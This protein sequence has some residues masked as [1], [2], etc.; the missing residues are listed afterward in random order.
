VNTY[1]DF[2]DYTDPVKPYIDNRFSFELLPNLMVTNNVYLQVRVS[3]NQYFRIMKLK[4]KIASSVIN[5]KD[6]IEISSV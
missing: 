1:F 5:Q 2:D 6:L 3:E 4:C